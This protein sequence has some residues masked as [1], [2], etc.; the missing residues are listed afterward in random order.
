MVD[1]SFPLASIIMS[2]FNG[3][4]YIDR[5]FQSILSQDYPQI[6]LLF[7]DDGSTDGSFEY[8]TSYIGDFEKRGYSLRLFQQENQGL[9]FA[10]I[11]LIPYVCGKYISY[12]DVDDEI[13]PQSI[14]I[15]VQALECDPTINVVRTNAYKIFESDGQKTLLVQ[16]EEEK[17]CRDLFTAILLGKANNYAGTYMVRKTV[18]D[19]FYRGKTILRSRYGQN[20]QLLLPSLYKS[21]S[22]FID[23][24]LM[25]YYIHAGSHSEQ[26]EL[27]KRIDLLTGYRNIRLQMLDYF[28]DPFYNLRKEINIAF[29]ENVL[30]TIISCQGEDKEKAKAMYNLHYNALK[31]LGGNKLE[32]RMYRSV[33]N[34]SPFQYAWRMIYKIAHL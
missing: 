19:E 21:K 20:L 22:I 34:R 7:V 13:L 15:R 9:G 27:L 4:Y 29:E 23:T 16:E 26:K 25:H 6:E 2:C 24:P 12:L 33:I 31:A 14:S 30:M 10:S 32:F 1:N 28:D 17:N 8:A 18:I 11:N 5:S 3:K